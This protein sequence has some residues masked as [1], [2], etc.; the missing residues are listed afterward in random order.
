MKKLLT[1]LVIVCMLSCS[2]KKSNPE[3]KNIPCPAKIV[4][5]TAMVS[6]TYSYG[7]TTKGSVLFDI[8]SSREGY[9][10]Y[11]KECDNIMSTSICIETELPLIISRIKYEYSKPDSVVYTFP[12]K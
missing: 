12:T 11:V 9:I 3:I 2:D 6:W 1:L 4:V 7:W 8:N 5:K 10:V